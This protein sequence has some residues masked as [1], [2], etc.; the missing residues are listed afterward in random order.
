MERGVPPDRAVDGKWS[1]ARYD[2]LEPQEQQFPELPFIDG[3][4]LGAF[5]KGQPR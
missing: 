2:L 5:G 3:I 1:I 4:P